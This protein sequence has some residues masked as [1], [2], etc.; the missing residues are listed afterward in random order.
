MKFQPD[1]FLVRH[2]KWR[3]A[4]VLKQIEKQRAF[5]DPYAKFDQI[6]G[7]HPWMQ[8]LRNAVVPYRVRELNKGKVTYFNFDLAREMGLLERNHPNKM[9]KELEKRIL[10][11]FNIRIIN[12]YDLTTNK[13]FDPKSLKPNDFMATRYLQLQHPNKQGKTSGDGRGIWNGVFKGNGKI[14]DV[15]SRGTGVTCLAPGS[16]ESKQPIQ[17]GDES[18]GYG[19]GLLEL[20]ELYGTAI[21]SE[22]FHRH[23]ISTE[24]ILTIIDTGKGHGIGVRVGC[25]LFRPAHLFTF[26]KQNDLVNLKKA[27]DFLIQR[28]F[29]NKDWDFDIS[30]KKKYDFMLENLC[31]NFAKFAARLDVDYIFAWLDWDGDNVLFNAGIIDYGSIR[32]FG[33][34][35]DQYR[36]DDVDRFSTTLNEQKHKTKFLIQVFAQITEFLKTGN[37]PPLQFLKEH[38]ILKQFDNHFDHYYLK[39]R[40][41]NIGFQKNDQEY[42]ISNHR[43]AVEKFE[44]LFKYFERQKTTKK[45]VK[46]PDGI[47]RP[48]IFNMRALLRELPVLLKGKDH[49][50]L[51]EPKFLFDLMIVEKTSR[52][53]KKMTDVQREKL[54][55]FQKAYKDLVES[56][57]RYRSFSRVV[58]EIYERSRIINRADRVTGN[59]IIMIVDKVMTLLRRGYSN[60]EIQKVID[61]FIQTQVLLPKEGLDDPELVL[62]RKSTAHKKLL[63]KIFSIVRAYKDDI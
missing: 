42:L 18:Y 55:E 19:C 22:I 1:I 17:T 46:I 47:N 36:Y 49:Q 60:E 40:L 61:S 56:T 3:T 28:Q 35:H 29:Q 4:K 9:S 44:I 51:V 45:M 26:L 59:G 20:D 27:V 37:K 21:Y 34:R 41:H 62:K 31:L 6:N 33:L 63:R 52:I 54:I 38:P 30:S 50:T 10:K 25:N 11:T 23:N 58:D 2:G 43:D 15:S 53:D 39:Y 12:E 48:A 57:R 8:E 5:A 13:K 24:R 7:N 14:W 16:V 32:Q